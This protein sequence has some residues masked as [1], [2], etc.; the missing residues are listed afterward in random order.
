MKRY[1]AET[2]G[3]DHLVRE[4]SIGPVMMERDHPVETL[5]LVCAHRALD[6]WAELVNG[7]HLDKDGA[8]YRPVILQKHRARRP[9]PHPLSS[10]RHPPLSQTCGGA[11]CYPWRWLNE[12]VNITLR[13]GGRETVALE[14]A[15]I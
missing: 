7:E 11:L 15:Q 3:T 4:D 2:G 14:K 12:R 1:T 5:D 8:T 9:H 10:A 13:G 6:N